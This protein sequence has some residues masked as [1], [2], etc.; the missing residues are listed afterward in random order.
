MPIVIL[1]LNGV[2]GKNPNDIGLLHIAGILP[3]FGRQ[4]DG[5]STAT[6]KMISFHILKKQSDEFFLPPVTFL[7][8]TP[9]TVAHSHE[10]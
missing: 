7:T 10:H 5:G 4:N 6:G 3:F 8:V 1:T 2:K 9:P